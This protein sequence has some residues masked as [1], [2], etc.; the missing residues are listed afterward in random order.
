VTGI[1]SIIL[2]RRIS[3]DIFKVLFYNESRGWKGGGAAGTRG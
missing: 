1:D 2:T 3:V